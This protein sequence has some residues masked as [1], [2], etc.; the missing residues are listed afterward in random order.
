[1]LVL[2]RRPGQSIRIGPNVEVRVVRI[3]GDRVVLGIAAPRHVAVVRAELVDEVSGELRDASNARAKLR[4][5][6]SPVHAAETT[7]PED[8]GV[9]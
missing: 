7:P 5:M 8:P 6:L 3:E 9:A 1:M 4:V 2:T